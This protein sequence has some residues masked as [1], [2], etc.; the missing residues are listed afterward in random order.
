MGL[1]GAMTDTC[2]PV[3]GNALLSY[4]ANISPMG[5]IVKQWLP[6]CTA[7]H[8]DVFGSS[9]ADP[10]LTPET[11]KRYPFYSALHFRPPQTWGWSTNI[12]QNRGKWNFSWLPRVRDTEQ[13]IDH[14]ESAKDSW[15]L[16]TSVRRRIRF[17]FIHIQS[18]GW[19]W[20]HLW[21]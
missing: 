12:L 10:V 2:L 11:G 20:S 9:T 4:Q 17:T 8:P 7:C 6:L 18:R 14:R 21:M 3:S 15:F 1:L 19:K 16:T 13:N 5:E